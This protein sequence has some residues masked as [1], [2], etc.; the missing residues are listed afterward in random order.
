MVSCSSVPLLEAIRALRCARAGCWAERR[1]GGS[2]RGRKE[3]GKRL[4]SRLSRCECSAR[5]RHLDAPCQALMWT[6]ERSNGRL[7]SSQKP[8]LLS[9][10]A[11]PWLQCR[12]FQTTLHPD[13]TSHPP[14]P[15]QDQAAHATHT[16][17]V[18]GPQK[19]RNSHVSHVVV[20]HVQCAKRSFHGCPLLPAQA[21]IRAGSLATEHQGSREENDLDA[22]E[23]LVLILWSCERTHPF[24]SSLLLSLCPSHRHTH[25][26]APPLHAPNAQ[27][28]PRGHGAP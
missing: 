20:V 21:S 23:D 24:S 5:S 28:C 17:C 10:L 15:N 25:R 16:A 13:N 11:R 1:G 6:C 19:A 8:L 3:G 27:P 7:L 22:R 26:P 2:S 4:L 12:C 9:F 14:Q 18:R